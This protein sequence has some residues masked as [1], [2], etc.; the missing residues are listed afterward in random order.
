MKLRRYLK[1]E[2]IKAVEVVLTGLDGESLGIISRDEA[3]QLAKQAGTDL[4]C[5]SLL[6]SPPPCQMMSKGEATKQR[7]QQKREE[8]KGLNPSKP[9]ELRLSVHIE[10]HD[11]DTKCRQAIKWLEQ[12]EQVLLTVKVTGKQ[13]EQAKALVDRLV[14]ELAAY[15]T[16]QTGIQ[17][18]GKQVS[19]VL[20]P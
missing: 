16:K 7:D 18:S 5:T 3:L 10:D 12:G 1:N 8:R 9:K 13:A 11:Y 17:Q 15:G 20:V 2:Q 14:T 6:E 4:V 19:V